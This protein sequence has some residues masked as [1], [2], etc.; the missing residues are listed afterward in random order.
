[1]QIVYSYEVMNVV[2]KTITVQKLS[3]NTSNRVKISQAILHNT[4]CKLQSHDV[5]ECNPS[6]NIQR[7]QQPYNRWKQNMFTIILRNIEGSAYPQPVIHLAYSVMQQ[8][9]LN[10]Y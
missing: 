2:P 10:N 8:H 4:I 5:I 9:F 7:K 3:N 1:M 6:S